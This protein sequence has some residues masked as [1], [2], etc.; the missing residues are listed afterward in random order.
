MA[1][2]EKIRKLDTEKRF[3]DV[4]VA[5]NSWI[6]G[7]L[8]DMI[9]NSVIAN[10]GYVSVSGDTDP[11]KH[12]WDGSMTIH[13]AVSPSAQEVVRFIKAAKAPNDIGMEDD[14]TLWIWYDG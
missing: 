13:F 8:R 6:D 3:R 12:R 10:G 2:A 14:K 4:F 1:V 7:T 5:F 11:V 9:C